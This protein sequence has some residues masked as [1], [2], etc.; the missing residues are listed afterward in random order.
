MDKYFDLVSIMEKE[1]YAGSY[2][3]DVLFLVYFVCEV[4]NFRHI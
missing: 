2:K 4:G 3:V 1:G